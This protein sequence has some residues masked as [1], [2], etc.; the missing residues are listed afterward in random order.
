LRCFSTFPF[1]FS[2]AIIYIFQ[3]LFKL[4]AGISVSAKSTKFTDHP[5]RAIAAPPV[6][7]H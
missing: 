3:A 2:V 1:A 6:N 7:N 5:A 4:T